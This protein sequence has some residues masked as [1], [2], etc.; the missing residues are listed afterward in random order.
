MTV[1]LVFG[2]FMPIHTGHMAL[3]D[4]AA[5]QCDKL[6]V[7]V[8]SLQK[9]PIPGDLRFQWVRELYKAYPKIQVESITDELPE[10]SR[11]NPAVSKAWAQ[12]LPKRFGKIDLLF[13]S[14]G[15]GPL[16]AHEMGISHVMFD[17]A[18]TAVP[19]SAT[20]IRE[21]P[22]QYWDFI[23]KV[24][25]PYFVKKVCVYGAESTGKTT[26][27]SQLARSFNTEWVPEMART[28]LGERHCTLDDIPAIAQLHASEIRRKL[29]LANRVLFVDTDFI[30]TQ[31]Y[32]EYYF[33]QVPREVTQFEREI[34]FDLYL[35]LD[36]DTPWVADSQRDCRDKR[37]EFHAWFQCELRKRKLPYTIVSGSWADR[38]LHAFNAVERLLK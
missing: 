2:K 10:D 26:L 16:V 11:P 18:R 28:I 38:Q 37:A 14:E 31:I 13:T 3:I 25:R 4:F 1:G 24:A 15:Y 5:R 6:I 29:P 23:P 9:E 7:A 32:S 19:I 34:H 35:L 36:I 33:G 17:Q 27:T 22:A 12:Y 30:T 20:Q 8:A 21:H